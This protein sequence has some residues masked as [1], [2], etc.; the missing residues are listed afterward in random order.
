MRYDSTRELV[1]RETDGHAVLGHANQPRIERD[2]AAAQLLLR[3]PAGPSNQ[4]AQPGQNL[5]DTKRLRDVVI[6]AGIDPVNRSRASCR[7]P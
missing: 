5:L 2:I 1:A 7:A 6:G 3:V 4:A